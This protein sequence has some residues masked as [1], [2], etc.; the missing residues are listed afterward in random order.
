MF[1]SSIRIK[2]NSRTPNRL[3]NRNQSLQYLN[4]NRNRCIH[5]SLNHL[6]RK[7]WCGKLLSMI[8]TLSVP[9]CRTQTR[10]S[11]KIQEK[12]NSRRRDSSSSNRLVKSI[13]RTRRNFLKRTQAG[14]QTKTQVKYLRDRDPLSQSQMTQN[15]SRGSRLRNSH[16]KSRQC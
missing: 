3:L 15:R 2:F 5:R 13:D 9:A 1:P 8:M 7:V 14:Y 4:R 10:S 6:L 12:L 11:I 16:Q